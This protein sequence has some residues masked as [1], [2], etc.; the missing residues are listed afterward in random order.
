MA[1]KVTLR[2][3]KRPEAVQTLLA[4]F[5][6]IEAAGQTVSDIIG[7]GMLPSAL[8]IMDELSIQAAEAAVHANYPSAVG[9]C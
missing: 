5:D 4:A 1:T 3:V 9:C 6:S 7:A 2:I 8:E